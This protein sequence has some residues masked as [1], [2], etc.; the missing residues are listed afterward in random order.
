MTKALLGPHRS[1]G[2]MRPLSFDWGREGASL[3]VR[4]R[5]SALSQWGR[6]A[7]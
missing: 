2:A 6:G 4:A 7:G 3:A 5:L 1:D